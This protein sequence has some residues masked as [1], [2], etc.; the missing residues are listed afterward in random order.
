MSLFSA[1]LPTRQPLFS[2][3]CFMH[4]TAP[5]TARR[6]T[7]ICIRMQALLPSSTHA[8]WTN[9]RPASQVSQ[10]HADC[11]VSHPCPK[12]W[13]KLLLCSLQEN[14]GIKT[15][16]RL[17]RA[18]ARSLRK[19]GFWRRCTW[20]PGDQQCVCSASACTNCSPASPSRY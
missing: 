15:L 14:L 5:G 16:K 3:A 2:I 12:C 7:M 18:E 4:L 6:T 1:L 10:P 17:G 19:S 8:R 20:Y 9:G 11:L 13:T